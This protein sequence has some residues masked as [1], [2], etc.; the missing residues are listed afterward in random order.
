MAAGFEWA[1][2]NGAPAGTTTILG[3]SGN[4][5]NLKSVDDATAAD[6]AANPITAGGNSFEVWL[7]AHFIGTFNTI[8]DVRFWQSTNFSPATGLQ[9]WWHNGGQVAYLQPFSG[10]SSI[11][12]SSIP[13]TDPGASNVSIGGNLSGSFVASGYTDFIVMQLRT[14]NAAPAGDTSLMTA[15]LSYSEN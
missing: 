8:R 9:V 12:T 6:Y 7:R 1:Q 2:T 14:T 10:T 5:A 4:L 15:T 3:T 13:I 11:A